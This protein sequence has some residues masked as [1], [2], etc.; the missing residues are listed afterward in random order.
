MTE[1]HADITRGSLTTGSSS[2]GRL[3][4][5]AATVAAAAIGAAIL[6]TQ[7]GK[8][9]TTTQSVAATLRLD[10]RPNGIAVGS[11]AI[12]V[13][14]NEQ[15]TDRAKQLDRINL[16]SGQVETSVPWTNG[17]LTF[18]KRR[19]DS[20]WVQN[21]GDRRDSTHGQLLEL[22]WASGKVLRKLA[23][24]KPTFGFAFG[25]GSLWIVV[26][27]EPATLVRLDPVTGER[28]GEPILLS[29]IR[30]IDLTFGAGALWA[31]ASEDG[32]LVRVDPETGKVD[33]VD[34]GDFPV[35]V[36][37]ADGAVWVT[38][39]ASGTVSRVDPATME[40]VDTIRVGTTP[41]WLE[42]AGGSIWV[43]NQDDGTVTRIDSATAETIGSP[44]KVASPTTD[45]AAHVLA[46]NGD[47]V[48][49]ASATEETVSRIDASN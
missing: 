6:F 33:K 26:G 13:A 39:R 16:A 20:L 45:A 18:S 38:N 49:V 4:V 29:P 44:I 30:V 12:W 41:T 32:T 22:D 7:V 21:V 14:L 28:Q 2:K 43:A 8:D 1:H 42:S 25:A 27:R 19:G 15:G 10:G 34:V 11:D 31:G 9:E 47:S 17:V 5:V 36:L 35:G 37:V 46:V 24:D 23:F 40:V 3:I 48:W